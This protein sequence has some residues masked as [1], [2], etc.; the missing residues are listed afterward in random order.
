ML[1]RLLS[2]VRQTARRLAQVL[3]RRLATTT[4]VAF[5]LV[6]G[7]L[8]DLVRSKPALI[9]ENALLRQQIIVLR[10]SVTRPRCTPVD[11]TLLVLLARRVRLWR[12]ALLIVQPD[13]LLRWRRRAF[14]CSGGGNRRR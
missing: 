2:R 9:A 11:R 14:A 5:P 13:T 7:T 6:A 4:P 8:D 3:G 10:R 1:T 12:Q